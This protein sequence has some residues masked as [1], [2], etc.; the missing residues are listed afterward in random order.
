MT[1]SSVRLLVDAHVHLYPF[2]SVGVLL[3]AACA[4]MSRLS[5]GEPEE[6][7]GILLLADPVGVRGYERLSHPDDR[8]DRGHWSPEDGDERCTMLRRSCGTRIVVIKGR[9]LITQEG[10]EVLAWACKTVPAGLSLSAT[11]DRITAVGGLSIIPWGVGKWFGKRGRLLTD[12]IMSEEGRRDILLADNGSRPWCWSRVPH[13]DTAAERGM[14]VIA[15]TDPLPLAGE[16]RRVG[17]YG[18]AIRV[19]RAEGVSTADLLHKE[20]VNTAT[21]IQII[22]KAMSFSRFASNQLRLRLQRSSGS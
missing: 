7:C 11:V 13:F 20:L 1:A 8:D 3:D 9:Q 19:E 2:M 4:N 14:R 10:L 21:A 5:P 6:Y 12:L 17:S 22:G 18:F 16:E 15:G